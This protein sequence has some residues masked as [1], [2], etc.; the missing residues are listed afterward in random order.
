MFYEIRPFLISDYGEVYRLWSQTEG[1]CMGDDDERDRI[2]LYLRRNPGLCYVS[3]IQNRV[4]G[5]VLC[6]HDGRRAILRHLA[7]DPTYRNQGMGRAL[8]D[9]VIASLR[10]QGIRKCN[11]YVQ[12]DNASGLRFWEQVGAQRLHENWRTLQIPVEP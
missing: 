10:G 3:V 1:L 5:T 12:D 8:V 4:V 11:L 9:K 2:E 7:V 6:G